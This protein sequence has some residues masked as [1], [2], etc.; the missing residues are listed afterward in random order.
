MSP[1]VHV[2]GDVYL[3]QRLPKLVPGARFGVQGCQHGELHFHP[4]GTLPRSF[5]LAAFTPTWVPYLILIRGYLFACGRS[6]R[7]FE[8]AKPE[9]DFHFPAKGFRVLDIKTA[10][11]YDLSHRGDTASHHMNVIFGLVIMA[12]QAPRVPPLFLRFPLC[13]LKPLVVL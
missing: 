4:Y 11:P 13:E 6:P 1:L 10:F 8:S 9:L 3:S 7:R 12:D 5:H 2:Q